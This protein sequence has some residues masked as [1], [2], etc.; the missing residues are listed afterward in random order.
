M[1]EIDIRELLRFFLKHLVGIIV[2]TLITTAV[3][4]GYTAFFKTP[5]YN[6]ETTIILINKQSDMSNMQTEI[7]V[8]QK[9]VETYS[10][11]IKSRKVLKKV[12]YELNLD[13]TIEALESMVSVSGVNNT[14]IINISVSSKDGDEAAEIA[15]K[16]SEVFSEEIREIYN[17]E[18]VSV[19]DKAE[20]Q[21]NPYNIN[22]KKDTLIY[23]AIGFCL[24]CFVLFII[25]YFD[26]TIKSKDQIEKVLEIPV[27]GNVPKI[28]KRG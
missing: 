12:K 15:N 19:I 5:L 4:L 21:A 28:G 17:L 13:Y 6:S 8:N 1:E 23:S 3:G 27:I 26:D 9:L 22:Y 11:I 2:M 25:Y 10:N 16:L 14:E 24:T 18:N 7:T 20:S